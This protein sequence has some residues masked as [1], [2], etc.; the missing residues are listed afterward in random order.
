MCC[1]RKESISVLL[2]SEIENDVGDQLRIQQVVPVGSAHTAHLD[3]DYLP[4]RVLLEAHE[5][6]AVTGGEANFDCS[7]AHSPCMIPTTC[8]PVCAVIGCAEFLVGC[9]NGL[10]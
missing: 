9:D 7:Y 2:K 5:G 4:W 10:A 6:P 3:L 8:P 1:F